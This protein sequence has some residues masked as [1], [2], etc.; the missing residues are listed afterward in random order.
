MNKSKATASRDLA[1]ARRIHGQFT[2]MFGRNFDPKNDR[3]KWTW[4]WSHYGFRT[5]ESVQA[6]YKKPVGKFP[7]DT[8]VMATEDSYCGFSATSWRAKELDFQLPY[9]RDLSSVLRRWRKG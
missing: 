6:G 9:A 7:F 3:V 5:R 2:R 4:D 1:L 8:R